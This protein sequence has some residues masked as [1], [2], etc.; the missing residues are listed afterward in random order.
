MNKRKKQKCPHPDC[1]SGW[2]YIRNV[3]EGKNPG[4][5]ITRS[6]CPICQG[7]AHVRRKR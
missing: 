5:V 4:E 7:L 6:L 3:I 1:V 2:V